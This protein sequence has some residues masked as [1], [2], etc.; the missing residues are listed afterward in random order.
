MP[1]NDTDEPQYAKPED[2][3]WDTYLKAS[4]DEDESRPKNWEGSTTGILTFTGLFAATVAAFIVESYTQLS[5]D[6]GD[7]AVQLL[8][9]L[10]AATANA[11]AGLPVIVTT[12][13]PFSTPPAA[14]ATNALWFSSLLISL[15]CALLST[16]V[17]EWSRAYVQ[18]INRRKVLHE[19]MRERAFNHI[20]IRMGV[21]RYGMDQFVSWIVALVHLAVFLSASGLLVFLFP[22]DHVVVGITTAILGIFVTIYWIAS[23]LPLLDKSCPYRTPITYLMAFAYWSVLRSRIGG[24]LL[25]LCQNANM[26]V[27]TTLH[28]LIK[29][30]YVGGQV[31]T[32]SRR[33]TETFLTGTRGSFLLEQTLAHI[34]QE[35]EELFF[36]LLPSFIN[37]HKGR[38]ALLSSLCADNE[39]MNRFYLYLSRS[40]DAYVDNPSSKPIP[41]E[42]FQ[43]ISYLSGRMFI[44]DVR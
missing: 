39:F 36:K 21:N 32:L 25:F 3:L 29:R 37:L 30:Q 4:K 23:L 43:L 12:P 6:S 22:I 8:S 40:H 20:Y 13:E 18:D 31:Q 28:D 24:V 9:Q 5:V 26:R 27:Q 17:Q 14:I 19:T 7:Q 2:F 42:I 41:L 15:I 44:S 1:E 11:S 34:S 35:N 33:V 16:L 38:N 10:L